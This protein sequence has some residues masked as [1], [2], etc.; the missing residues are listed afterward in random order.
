MAK[1]GPFHSINVGN[2]DQL[3]FLRLDCCKNLLQ[4][5]KR[6]TNGEIRNIRMRS[7]MNISYARVSTSGMSVLYGVGHRHV[8]LS[9][10]RI[11][12]KDPGARKSLFLQFCTIMPVSHHK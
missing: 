9:L 5:E 4:K 11:S 8:I 2:D 1:G 12:R 10:A 6:E 3:I 7:D